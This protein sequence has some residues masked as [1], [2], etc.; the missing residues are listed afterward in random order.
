MSG[1]IKLHRQLIDWEWYSDIN[2]SRLFIHCLL[3]ANYAPKK[4]RGISINK[5]QFWTS[6]PTLEAETGLSTSQLRTSINKLKSTGDIAVKSQAQ[7]RMVTVS[8]YD[9]YQED[10][11]Q[12]DSLVTGQSQTSDRPVTANKNIKKENKERKDQEIVIP[13]GINLSAWNEWVA[14]RKTKKKTVSQAAA[15]KQFKLLS[16]YSTSDQQLV[17]DNSISNDYQGLFELKGNSNGQHQQ[18]LAQGQTKRQAA[19][20]QCDED[21]ANLRRAAEQSH[22]QSGG[23]LVD[24]GKDVRGYLDQPAWPDDQR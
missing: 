1:W 14:Y 23:V 21:L 6:L 24:D 3:R 4:W 8:N 15:K 18:P 5:G 19:L 11:R 17:I 9:S 12:D 20:R 16:N 22:S 2:T 7:G 13:D 10:D